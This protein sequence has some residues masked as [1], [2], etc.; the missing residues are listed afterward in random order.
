MTSHSG[1]FICLAHLLEPLD[2]YLRDHFG[3]KVRVLRIKKHEG[4]IRCRVIGA[5]PAKGEILVFLDSH[6]EAT[7]GWFEPLLATVMQNT[8][9][10][11]TPVIDILEKNTFEYQYSKSDR[12]QVGGFDWNLVVNNI[13]IQKLWTLIFH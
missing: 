9:T 6:I 12:V 10:V 8:T 11:A 7:E 1:V 3:D 2:T 4:I 13:F 5:E